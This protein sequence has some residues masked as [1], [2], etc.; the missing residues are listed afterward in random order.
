MGPRE[1]FFCLLAEA[2]N[3][4]R[5]LVMIRFVA[6]ERGVFGGCSAAAARQLACPS[7]A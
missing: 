4:S 7:E 6:K 1:V 2:I 5:S 3:A